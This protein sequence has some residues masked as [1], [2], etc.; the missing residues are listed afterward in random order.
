VVINLPDAEQWCPGRRAGELD[1]N[2][3]Q[4]L[5]MQRRSAI[6]TQRTGAMRLWAGTVTIDADAKTARTIMA[7]SKASF[8]W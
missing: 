8:M 3:P 5:G 7:T 2:T 1:G 4:T 6:T